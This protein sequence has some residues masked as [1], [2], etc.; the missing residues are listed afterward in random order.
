MSRDEL[1]EMVCEASLILCDDEI[2]DEIHLIGAMLQEYEVK[3]R[4]IE[5]K[6]IDPTFSAL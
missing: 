6:K 5:G 3:L 2:P 1:I 4:N